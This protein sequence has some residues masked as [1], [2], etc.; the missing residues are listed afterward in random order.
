MSNKKIFIA[1]SQSEARSVVT[2]IEFLTVGCVKESGDTVE[3]NTKNADTI[4]ITAQELSEL[5]NFR[6]RLIEL[7]Y[8]QAELEASIDNPRLT[9]EVGQAESSIPVRPDR[10]GGQN[11]ESSIENQP[12]SIHP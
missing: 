12:S 9:D 2:A 4:G 5:F 10:P 1:I 11:P 6:Q 3:F 8:E 7:A